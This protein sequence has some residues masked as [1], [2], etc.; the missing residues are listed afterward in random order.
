MRLRRALVRRPSAFNGQAQAGLC[1]ADFQGR[2]EFSEDWCRRKID[3]EE[4][5][6]GRPVGL[7]DSFHFDAS[8]FDTFFCRIGTIDEHPEVHA[9]R[10]VAHFRDAPDKPQAGSRRRLEEAPRAAAGEFA[11]PVPPGPA[12]E[13]L[14]SGEAQHRNLSIHRVILALPNANTLLRRMV[15]GPSDG[16]ERRAGP[17]PKLTALPSP[18]RPSNS[19]CRFRL[20]IKEERAGRTVAMNIV[21]TTERAD[22]SIAKETGAGVNPRISSSKPAS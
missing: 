14:G 7:E 1:G 5:V 18:S 2:G 15:S 8:R 6:G 21:P 10:D 22:L 19:A 17:R 20:L 3:E 13:P 16:T 4:L 9:R 12:E 11:R